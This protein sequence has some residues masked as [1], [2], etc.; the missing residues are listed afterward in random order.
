M[1][2]AVLPGIDIYR[3]QGFPH[4]RNRRVAL[5]ANP[6]G[7]SR[8]LQRTTEIL[9]AAPEIRLTALL[10]PEHGPEGIA[11]DAAPV[12]SHVDPCTGLPV[13]SL[14]GQTLRPT[15]EM[16]QDI[17]VI[18]VDLQDVGV[19][20]YTYIWTVTHVMEAAAAVGLPV[21]VL[22]R[23]NPLGGAVQGPRL[24]PGFESFLGRQDI[25]LRHGMTIGELARYCN[26]RA[27][28]GTDLTV[29]PLA[30]WR[31]D[32]CWEDTGL[33]WVPPSPGLPTLDAVLLYPGTCL[34]EGTNLSEGRGTA[35]PFQLIG[36][37][38]IDARRWATYLNDL[39]LPGVLFRATAFVPLDSKWARQTCW[40]VQIHVV[41]RGI[42]DPLRVGLALLTTIRA[43]HPDDFAWLPSSWEG[44]R[45]H[46][47]L[48]V[49]NAW[50]RQA[51]DSGE[52]ID[53]IM[54][55]WEEGE[56]AFQQEREPFLLYP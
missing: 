52:P 23:P 14:Y 44:E 55:R 54:R 36:A 35:L 16:L 33:I 4:L 39:R 3:Q 29:V 38:W 37:P 5:L 11:P 40:G 12:S 13:F 48:L 15:E 43:L 53:A 7:V 41:E 20:F 1:A 2:P 31:R 6:S 46:F 50:V 32:M 45:P 18:V 34:V 25:P 21:I 22:D 27:R 24:E 30:G 49:G 42:V 10:S 26:E 51:I 8:T 47:D 17:D 56:R 9:Q 28:L 19:R